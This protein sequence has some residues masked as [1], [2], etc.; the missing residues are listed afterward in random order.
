MHDPE[1][2]ET[3]QW[4]GLR[5]PDHSRWYADR[6]R[7]MAARGDDLHGESRLVD[8]L[9][10]RHARLLDAGCGPGRHGGHLATLGHDVVGVDIDPLLIDAARSDH[11][12]ASWHVAD[13]ATLDLGRVF[14]GILVAGNVIDFVAPAHRATV[15][16]RLADHLAPGGFLVL[17]CRTTQGF[18]PDD[19][20]TA[21]QGTALEVEHRFATWDLRPWRPGADFCVTVLRARN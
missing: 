21:V 9:A 14:D 18:T 5:D 1:A 20:D 13:L 3:T 10:P 15:I 16:H 17:G 19:L 4:P 6:F 7:E 2:G 12:G 11:P 8:A